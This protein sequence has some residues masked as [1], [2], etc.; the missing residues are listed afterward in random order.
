MGEHGC[1]GGTL[2]RNRSAWFYISDVKSPK[3]IPNTPISTQPAPNHPHLPFVIPHC[4]HIYP[5]I[6]CAIHSIPHVQPQVASHE[7]VSFGI[8]PL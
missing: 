7:L 4:H 2:Q 3:P 5:P 1:V 6:V 8:G